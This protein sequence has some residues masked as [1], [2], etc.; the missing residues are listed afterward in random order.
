MDERII[1]LKGR[2][3]RNFDEAAESILQM[4]STIVDI[5]TLFI[6]RNDRKINRIVK[7][8]N[9][10]VDLIKEGE[11]L[12]YNDTFCKLSI[13]HGQKALVIED[14]L[15]NHQTKRLQVT[16][17]LGSGTFI[18]IPIYYENGE[19]YGTI[20]GLDLNNITLSEKHIEIFETMAS[21][22]TFVLELEKAN[23]QITTLTAPIVPITKGVAILPIIG[24][25]TAKRAENIIKIT[26]DKSHEYGLDYLILDLSAVTQ[27]N[28][29]VSGALLKLVNILEIIGVTPILT[30]FQPQ[31]AMNAIQVHADLKDIAVEASL[32]RAL[33]RIGF[34]LDRK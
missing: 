15:L 7:A 16:E 24:E 11:E 5:N 29:T 26:L 20:C 33:K 22:L 25:I 12:P 32:E 17:K 28:A 9:S 8:T 18:G 13:D 3:F 30:G 34:V 14:I 10:K 4:M 27:M 21:L 6:A 2:T 1:T 23:E 19:N 31:L